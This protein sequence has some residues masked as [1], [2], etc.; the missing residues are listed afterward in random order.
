MED[1]GDSSSQDGGPSIPAGIL[2]TSKR[3]WA[4]EELELEHRKEQNSREEYAAVNIKQFQNTEVGTGYQARGVVRQKTAAG[5]S[6]SS[7]RDMTAKTDTKIVESTEKQ[8]RPTEVNENG[9]ESKRKR[10]EEYLSCD[11]IREFRKEIEQ[12]LASDSTSSKRKNDMIANHD[13][14]R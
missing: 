2:R 10:L 12:L 5:A 6:Q 14:R 13:L 8:K 3:G 1:D 7:I 9:A 11:G 4:G